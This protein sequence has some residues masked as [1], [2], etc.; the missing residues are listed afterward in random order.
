MF[1]RKKT[2]IVPILGFALIMWIGG[3][4]LHLPICHKGN[5][6]F[7]DTLFTSVSSVTTTGMGV[8]IISQKFTIV[9]QVLIAILMNIG[10]VGFI[11]LITLIWKFQNKKIKISDM[12]LINDN[13]AGNNYINV[14]DEVMQI[15]K[16]VVTIELIGTIL[17]SIRF[18][19]E[20]G[21]WKGL[22]YSI[23]HSI[24]AFS[25]TGFDLFEGT[26]FTKYSSDMYV[27]II[28]IILMII[29]GI[30]FLTLKDIFKNKQRK[31]SKLRLQTKI[32]I[33]YSII[34]IVV[35]TIV[36]KVFE[37]QI[38]LINSLF[39]GVTTRSTGLFTNNVATFGAI[40][41]ILII[42][43]MFI[44]GAPGST[45]GGIK[46]IVFAVIEAVMYSTL[47]GKD[48]VIVFWKKINDNIIKM[49]CTIISVFILFIF[50]AAILLIIF[51]NFGMFDIFFTCISAISTT[52][53][54]TVDMQIL[55]NIGKIITIFL[56]F[57][58]RIGPLSIIIA[59]VPNEN[60]KNEMKYPEEE[61]IL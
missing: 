27:S 56:M 37:P 18:V 9:G 50:I 51:N 58:G 15:L 6:K 43:L 2:Y 21:F 26:S 41:K 31:F 61:L 1:K 59:V 47:K 42:L 22:W 52:G 35:P 40:S 38:S 7:I 13:I 16:Y 49:A 33:I 24:S 25:N 39:M 57:A 45:A 4:L 8:N 53:L 54:V 19:P 5:I 30:G 34:L 12:K 17:L 29:G 23:F 48:D 44:G 11:S 55:N 60:S 36:L 32:V 28:I 10:A 46:I 14:K 20:Y 3:I